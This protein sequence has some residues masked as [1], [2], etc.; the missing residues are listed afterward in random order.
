MLKEAPSGRASQAALDEPSLREA[1]LGALERAGLRSRRSLGRGDRPRL[2]RGLSRRRPLVRALRAGREA[3][4][5]RRRDGRLAA[6]ACADRRADHRQQ[7][8]DRRLGRCLLPSLDARE[9]PVP[10]AVVAEDR[11]LSYKALF[12]RSLSADPERLHFAAHSHHLW[13]DASFEGQMEAWNDAARLADRKWDKVMGEVWPA[14]RPRSRPSS[15]PAGPTPSFSRPTRMIFSSGLFTAAPRRAGQL[16]VLTSDGEFHSARR[17]FARWEE[18][19]WIGGRA[20]SRPSRS[21]ASPIASSTPRDPAATT[22]SS[23]VR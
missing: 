21:T 19:G 12:S 1:A 7:A 9:A 22:S 23:S 3:A 4:R 18:E 2:A 6:Q 8:R 15:E 10:R 14:P 5:H 17:Q 16:R 13:P 11:S 20:R